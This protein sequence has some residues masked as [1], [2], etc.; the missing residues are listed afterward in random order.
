MINYSTSN[1]PCFF[2]QLFIVGPPRSHGIQN[3]LKTVSCLR[4]GVFDPGRH[5][6]VDCPDKKSIFFHGSEI[7]CQHL[8]RDFPHSLPQLAES[9]G[10]FQQFSYYQHL[11]TIADEHEGSFDGTIREFFYHYASPF[12]SSS[13]SRY[14]Q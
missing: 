10:P 9:H 8:G 5:F 7:G 4:Q 11:P 13:F 1:C 12:Q 14:F 6:G 3:K 2:R